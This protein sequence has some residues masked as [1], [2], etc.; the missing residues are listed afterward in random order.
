MIKAAVEAKG[1]DSPA[2]KTKTAAKVLETE[3]GTKKKGTHD[4]Q[5]TTLQALKVRQDEAVASY[6]N[7]LENREADLCDQ[8]LQSSQDAIKQAAIRMKETEMAYNR[9][10]NY[11]LLRTQPEREEHEIPKIQNELLNMKCINKLQYMTLQLEIILHSVQT[12]EE[13]Q[14][15]CQVLVSILELP[16][17]EYL[18]KVYKV[19]RHCAAVY[20]M[21]S[22]NHWVARTLERVCLQRQSEG[23]AQFLKKTIEQE[24]YNAGASREFSQAGIC[25]IRSAANT[26]QQQYEQQ[27]ATLWQ[28]SHCQPFDS[29]QLT[30]NIEIKDIMHT[31]HTMTL[32]LTPDFHYE[33]TME[34]KEY[35][36]ISQTML[37]GAQHLQD[38]LAC[39][40]SIITSTSEN[41]YSNLIEIY[42]Y[43]SLQKGAVF[44]GARTISGIRTLANLNA[45]IDLPNYPLLSLECPAIMPE[46][47]VIEAL[48]VNKPNDGGQRMQ[49]CVRIINYFL[50]RQHAAGKH[51]CNYL[52]HHPQL[53]VKCDYFLAILRSIVSFTSSGTTTMLD[54]RH[55]LEL[56]DA[57]C[58]HDTST[59]ERFSSRSLSNGLGSSILWIFP[60]LVHHIRE[61]CTQQNY[62]YTDFVEGKAEWMPTLQLLISGY[63]T[64][65]SET[66]NDVTEPCRE[67]L[68]RLETV[69]G[70]MSTGW[71]P[72]LLNCQFV[73]T[74]S[75]NPFCQLLVQTIQ[76]GQK[77][78]SCDPYSAGVSKQEIWYLAALLHKCRST[79]CRILNEWQTLEFGQE[80]TPFSADRVQKFK[81]HIQQYLCDLWKSWDEHIVNVKRNGKQL[82][83]LLTDLLTATTMATDMHTRLLQQLQ[84][85]GW[86]YDGNDCD[87]YTKQPNNYV[88]IDSAEKIY[89]NVAMHL[90]EQLLKILLSENT[91][92][93]DR[94]S[95]IHRLLQAVP[96]LNALLHK[97]DWD[98][99]QFVEQNSTEAKVWNAL[100][101][102]L[103]QSFGLSKCI[104]SS[105]ALNS[106]G[107]SWHAE[108]TNYCYLNGRI[109]CHLKHKFHQLG[110]LAPDITDFGVYHLS[111]KVA[112]HPGTEACPLD[113]NKPA[114][115][116]YA[117]LHLYLFYPRFDVDALGWDASEL[118][119]AAY[120]VK[121]LSASDK[122]CMNPTNGGNS[123][124]KTT[125]WGKNQSI[126]E[127][128]LMHLSRETLLQLNID[129]VNED[130]TKKKHSTK[131]E[132]H[133][134]FP[135][136]VYDAV[137]GVVDTTEL[138]FGVSE[139]MDPDC[140]S[141]WE[142]CFR[143]PLYDLAKRTANK[144]TEDK[145]HTD[146]SFHLY[147]ETS[148]MMESGILQ[149]FTTTELEHY[150]HD[151]RKLQYGRRT[152]ILLHALTMQ[153]TALTIELHPALEFKK[154]AEKLAG[155]L[156]ESPR[157][158]ACET[159][160]HVVAMPYFNTLSRSKPE[161]A[162]LLT[163]VWQ[164]K[165]N[166]E[167]L[168]NA[169]SEIHSLVEELRCMVWDKVCEWMDGVCDD[170]A[171]M[172][173][174]QR[175]SD[176]AIE[177]P[178]MRLAQDVLQIRELMLELPRKPKAE[179]VAQAADKVQ[180]L[181][182]TLKQKGMQ[183]EAEKVDKLAG[184]LE[185][186]C[187][188]LDRLKEATVHA[189]MKKV[190]DAAAAVLAMP[191]FNVEA[192]LP[193][194]PPSRIHVIRVIVGM[195][196]GCC[197]SAVPTE[198]SLLDLLLH[199]RL[200][201]VYALESTKEVA[202]TRLHGVFRI[203]QSMQ[204]VPEDL[205]SQ[206]L[207]TCQQTWYID[208][209]MPVAKPNSGISDA[210][211][212][213][214][215]AC[216]RTNTM[217]KASSVSH[218][219]HFVFDGKQ[220]ELPLSTTLVDDV[221]QEAAYFEMAE[222]DEEGERWINLNEILFTKV[223]GITQCHG[224]GGL[225]HAET[226]RAIEQLQQF[227]CSGVLLQEPGPLRDR[228]IHPDC[229]RVLQLIDAL[230][231]DDKWIRKYAML[232]FTLHTDEAHERMLLE[233]HQHSEGIQS[234]FAALERE[235]CLELNKDEI[236]QLIICLVDPGFGMQQGFW[237]MECGKELA[238]RD[239]V[240]LQ[241]C[242]KCCDRL[243]GP[244]KERQKQALK[245]WRHTNKKKLA[246][247]V[248]N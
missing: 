189:A 198:S 212:Q 237:C 164:M 55:L 224:I 231:V 215:Q 225:N 240:V 191:Y 86:T 57:E 233:C 118:G 154:V 27:K 166:D 34:F 245:T 229:K 59:L 5:T 137:K 18:Y 69:F 236:S 61:D 138:E 184:E 110:D 168:D 139:D 219:V 95:E 201:R 105:T 141:M 74:A 116:G 124:A 108:W 97:V 67:V 196:L 31:D 160:S 4:I 82:N 64:M 167:E 172:A 71:I 192:R 92:I 152:S 213:H 185:E 248:D 22:L 58:R 36:E 156:E 84:S 76:F 16:E 128:L 96:D 3:L 119:P 19:L 78:T 222:I 107:V 162:R 223:D 163:N 181:T 188:V 122:T 155:E 103:L 10:H 226:K 161:L 17:N 207:Y 199:K 202:K 243:K 144:D 218:N 132:E 111:C 29:M 134:L 187:I 43:F 68:S 75:S 127:G 90:Q 42:K 28:T 121:V 14:R 200:K 241:R 171:K 13:L 146:R 126:L 2:P 26:M 25:S 38:G 115:E 81:R 72:P 183:T 87:G 235:K 11:E 145:V 21:K 15:F 45:E 106:L 52:I 186:L 147:R 33:R 35:K 194:E 109:K 175:K 100:A 62:S 73:P 246:R 153:P 239:D 206:L 238:Q 32:D 129:G 210:V 180:H 211:Q 195:K 56:L 88:C 133:L 102:Q 165:A 120:I 176:Y 203:L 1:T 150:L 93:I 208:N 79:P 182:R 117:R 70:I 125:L 178:N 228:Q 30:F 83:S 63:H 158:K 135:E 113:W 46:S 49:L 174:C 232:A 193:D 8:Q 65:L 104:H 98:Y 227:V 130:S 39:I 136:S 140:S 24:R 214:L 142:K 216:L 131:K 9:E 77:L 99:A 112:L 40:Q 7:L 234:F 20:F 91:S 209:Y 37:D 157:L 44:P 85:T 169:A 114:F 54:F 149:A 48:T 23:L 94:I 50:K 123:V 47:A 217:R 197:A 41:F 101:M 6:E 190:S 204:K 143:V 177:I 179:S 230:D 221:L 51:K 66:C 12:L 151:K 244:A 205:K 60:E 80:R 89:S 148:T 53:H 220:F 242:K 170:Y 159:A 173:G 247:L